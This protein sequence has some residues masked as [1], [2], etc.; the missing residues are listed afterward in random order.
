MTKT[1]VLA[2]FAFVVV[3][4]SC[5]SGDEEAPTADEPMEPMMSFFLTSAGPGD[6]A[7]LGGL[8]GADA[9]C[10]SLAAAVGGLLVGLAWAIS[11]R[12]AAARP[13]P[14]PAPPAGQPAKSTPSRPE[15]A[16]LNLHPCLSDSGGHELVV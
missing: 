14:D 15:T 9:Y 13:A 7:N 5:A 11:C 8:E 10:Q 12:P 2:L 16:N 4:G 3:A 6:G 1:R